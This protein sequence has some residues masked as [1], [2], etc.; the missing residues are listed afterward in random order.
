MEVVPASYH[1]ALLEL[2]RR[3]GFNRV[4][5]GLHYESDC[6]AGAYIADQVPAIL[7][8]CDTYKL[9]KREITKRHEW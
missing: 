3:V 9:V 2:A 8:D 7:N 6:D 1:P 5:A 4:I